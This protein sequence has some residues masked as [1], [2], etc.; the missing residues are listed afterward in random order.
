MLKYL[1]IALWLPVS[2]LAQNMDYGSVKLLKGWQDDDG[3]YQIAL[4]FA[5]N[6]GWKTYWR[7]PGP[8]GLPPVFNWESSANIGDVRY[9]WPI[10]EVIRQ[11]GMTTL[12][13]RDTFVLPI[14]ITPETDSPVRL[15]MNLNFGVCSDICVPAQAVFLA[16][17]NGSAHEGEARIEAA[18]ARAPETAED[19]GLVSIECA[20]SPRFKGSEITAN[21]TFDAPMEGAFIVLESDDGDV[22][23]D[24]PESTSHGANLQAKAPMQYYGFGE[25]ELDFAGLTVSVFTANRAVEIEGCPE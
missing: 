6:D 12:G 15:A 23:I 17:L 1:F 3:N 8:A 20:V 2:A 4:E 14:T 11:A 16:R 9:D 19:A 7:T 25:M 10:P 13:Y 5:L 24:M 21:M 18:L 22:W